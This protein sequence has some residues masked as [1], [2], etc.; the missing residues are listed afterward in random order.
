MGPASLVVHRDRTAAA[1][2]LATTARKLLFYR[3]SKRK[4]IIYLLFLGAITITIC[5]HNTKT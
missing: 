5:P 1:P 4:T 3:E 2:F